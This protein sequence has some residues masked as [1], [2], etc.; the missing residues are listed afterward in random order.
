MQGFLARHEREQQKK[1]E[2]ETVLQKR[3]T[4]REALQG[5]HDRAFFS[6]NY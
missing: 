6:L 1:K 5:E 2:L 3:V 4:E